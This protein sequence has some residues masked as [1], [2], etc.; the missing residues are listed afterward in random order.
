MKNDCRKELIKSRAQ[1]RDLKR[2][3]RLYEKAV[4]DFQVFAGIATS[5][6]PNLQEAA[7]YLHK[8]KVRAIRV[9]QDI[10]EGNQV[11]DESF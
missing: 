6:M 9:H 2:V 7:E 10:K 8:V 5:K 4:G 11:R 1:V 3:V